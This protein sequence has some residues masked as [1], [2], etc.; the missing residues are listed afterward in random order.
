MVGI[1]G[2]KFNRVLKKGVSSRDPALHGYCK[3]SHMSP[4][5][6]LS[7]SPRALADGLMLVF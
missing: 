3:C 7:E 1:N 4:Y 6:G 5:A 2:P